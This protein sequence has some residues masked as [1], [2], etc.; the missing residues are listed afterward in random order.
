MRKT[1]PRATAAG[2][3]LQVLGLM[4]LAGGLALLHP[5]LGAVALGLGLVA[6]GVVLEVG[7]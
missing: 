2:S 4:V 6:V 1:A 7:G 3:A 5:W